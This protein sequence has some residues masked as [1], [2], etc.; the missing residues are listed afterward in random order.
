MIFRMILT[1]M[2]NCNHTEVYIYILKSTQAKEKINSRKSHVRMMSRS[3]QV[4]KNISMKTHDGSLI[5]YI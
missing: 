1:N 3:S 4:Y 2:R 5:E